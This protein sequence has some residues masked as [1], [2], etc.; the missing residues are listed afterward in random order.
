MYKLMRKAGAD[1]N[2]FDCNGRL[3]KYYLKYPDEL[4]LE[5]MRLDT[6]QALKQILHT[7]VDLHI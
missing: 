4:N 1:P 2:T 6:K 3:P 7:C 5:R